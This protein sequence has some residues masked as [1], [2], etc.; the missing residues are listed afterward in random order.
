MQKYEFHLKNG[1]LK[2]FKVHTEM[3]HNDYLKVLKHTK[4]LKN[5]NS[6]VIICDLSNDYRNKLIHFINNLL[7]VRL[8]ISTFSRL[9]NKL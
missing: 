6:I 9:M 5:R 7:I 8:L 1:V 4:Y 3:K 2:F